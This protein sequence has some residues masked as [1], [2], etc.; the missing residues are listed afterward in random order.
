MNAISH[1]PLHFSSRDNEI[2]V[3]IV[4]ETPGNRGRPALRHLDFSVDCDVL[5]GEAVMTVI[6]CLV[7]AGQLLGKS[8]EV[9]SASAEPNEGLPYSS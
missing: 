5:G 9:K 6:E 8:S 2:A 7:D 3:E 1:V 4:A